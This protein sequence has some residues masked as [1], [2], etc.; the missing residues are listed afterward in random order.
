MKKA[1][2]YKTLIFDYL[3]RILKKL[4]FFCFNI[5]RKY[6]ALAASVENV[7]A[8]AREA[9]HGFCPAWLHIIS[10]IIGG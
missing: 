3:Y 9:A 4:Q 5:D 8:N 2:P 6:L 1:E 7:M 10:M